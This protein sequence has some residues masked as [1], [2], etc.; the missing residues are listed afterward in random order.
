MYTNIDTNHA[1]CI[2][3]LWLDELSKHPDFPEDFPLEAV[4]EAIGYIMRNNHFVFGDLN[5]LQILGTAM[6]TSAACIWA[7][8]YYGYHEV[9]KLL[10]TFMKQL[11]DGKM[12]R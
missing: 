7:T 5:F 12:V 2:I 11:Y 6:G 3:C 9:K 10:P 4:K 1:I 8:I